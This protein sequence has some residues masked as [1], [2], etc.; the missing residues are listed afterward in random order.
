MEI[1]AKRVLVLGGWGLAGM[2]VCRQSLDERPEELIV[3]S[4]TESEA[5]SACERLRLESKTQT[6]LTPVHGNIFLGTH[7]QG[8]SRREILDSEELRRQLME[9]VL[10][11]LDEKMLQRSFLYGL[12]QKHKPHIIVDCVNSATAV[13]Y[14]D[15]FAS[16]YRLRPQIESA[17]RSRNASETLLAEVEKLLCT[18]Y[19]PQLIRHVQILYEAMRQAGTLFYLKIGTSGT[20]GMG[21]NIPYTHSEERPSRV[22]LSKSSVAGAHTMLLFLMART[23]DAPITKEIKPTAAIA[24]KR[25]EYGPIVRSGQPIK[26]YDCPVEHATVLRGTLSLKES[27]QLDSVDDRV[28]ESV[29]ID[30]GENGIFSMGEFSAISSSGQMEFVTPEEIA[31][32]VIYEIKGGSTGHD[33]INALDNAVMGPT[34]RAG[35]MRYDALRQMQ[36]LAN[37]H[38]CES[39]AFELLGP[40]RLSKLLW[41]AQLLN[42]TAGSLEGVLRAT[43]EELAAKMEARVLA[44]STLRS[45]IISI[46]IPLLLRDGQRLLRGP[47]IKIPPYRGSDRLQISQQ[48]IDHWTHDGWVDLRVANIEQ[49]KH[50]IEQIFEEMQSIPEDDT[51]SRYDRNRRYWLEDETINIGKVVGWIFSNEEHGR[52]M[53]D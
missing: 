53:K 43:A 49:W 38:H 9:D 5:T 7:L 42:I 33:I 27:R 30:T 15:V 12:I 19:V 18:L 26:L 47:E 52:R 8:K 45:H 29:Y 28:L 41:E 25:I 2:A 40:P 32:N 10:G 48:N 23:P 16:Y 14:Q 37:Q 34:Y 1:R 35:I 21:L 11:E 31:R 24:W 3:S 6:K 13:A 20:G 4:L 46:G 39:V 36:E 17:R 44:D 50:R 22:L 51:S